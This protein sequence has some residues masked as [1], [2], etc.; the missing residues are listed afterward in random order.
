MQTGS[1]LEDCFIQLYSLFCG[2]YIIVAVLVSGCNISMFFYCE[3]TI[4][5]TCSKVPPTFACAAY[6]EYHLHCQNVTKGT[7]ALLCTLI[8]SAKLATNV[9]FVH[10]LS[11]LCIR[12]HTTQNMSTMCTVSWFLLLESQEEELEWVPEP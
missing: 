10:G 9:P 8:F 11:S 3:S 4:L 6:K 1:I 2:F 5:S 12:Y 7:V